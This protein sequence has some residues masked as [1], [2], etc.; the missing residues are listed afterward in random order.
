[1]SVS[2][3]GW[4]A[5]VGVVVLAVF[6]CPAPALCPA[7]CSAPCTIHSP[8]SLSNSCNLACAALLATA[9]VAPAPLSTS[10]LSCNTIAASLALAPSPR[11]RPSPP[12]PPPFTIHRTAPFPLGPWPPKKRHESSSCRFTH[13]AHGCW[14]SHFSLRVRQGMHEMTWR[15]RLMT[16]RGGSAAVTAVTAVTAVVVVVDDD[17][18]RGGGSD[19]FTAPEPEALVAV[20]IPADEQ[21]E[22][23]EEAEAGAG[24]DGETWARRKTPV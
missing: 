11:S 9:F 19:A 7:L 22:E 20:L 5:A 23:E 12:L 3:R 18:G 10:I 16:L 1:M 17:G 2:L 21:E 15:L 24:R 6:V 4:L 8:T 14:R 13:D